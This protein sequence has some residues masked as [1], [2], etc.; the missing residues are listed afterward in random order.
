M[1]SSAVDVVKKTT[2]TGAALHRLS[3]GFGFSSMDPH[4]E[5]GISIV[6]FGEGAKYIAFCGRAHWVPGF[7]FDDLVDDANHNNTPYTIGGQYISGFEENEKVGEVPLQDQTYNVMTV[8]KEL[9]KSFSGNLVS[10]IAIVSASRFMASENFP[11]VS[12]IVAIKFVLPVDKGKNEHFG[13]F[14]TIS[15]F[16]DFCKGMSGLIVPIPTSNDKT[17]DPPIVSQLTVGSGGVAAGTLNGEDASYFA[18]ADAIDSTVHIFSYRSVV[19][20]DTQRSARENKKCER[21]HIFTIEVAPLVGKPENGTC[22]ISKNAASDDCALLVVCA[23]IYVNEVPIFSKVLTF[24]RKMIFVSD[25]RSDPSYT[26]VHSVITTNPSR[27][28]LQAGISRA[29]NVLGVVTVDKATLE[30]NCKLEIYIESITTPTTREWVKAQEVDIDNTLSRLVFR[31]MFSPSP[32]SDGTIVGDLIGMSAYTSVSFFGMSYSGKVLA[33]V[34]KVGTL[35]TLSPLSRTYGTVLIFQP[36]A[37]PIP[38][39][40]MNIGI[41][42]VERVIDKIDTK[43]GLTSDQS[44]YITKYAAY[45]K[46]ISRGGMQG[47]SWKATLPHTPPEPWALDKNS[48]F[49]SGVD[50][51]DDGS[52]VSLFYTATKNVD[53]V[54]D[55]NGALQTVSIPNIT[56]NYTFFDGEYTYTSIDQAGQRGPLPLIPDSAIDERL[57][58]P[59]TALLNEYG[60]S[61]PAGF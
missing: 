29:G 48:V 40:S 24:S 44:A 23:G 32:A 2:G 55:E 46:H 45:L 31:E 9:D 10:N 21:T 1:A 8:L 58:D 50:V 20:T 35:N 47:G 53:L 37:I 19:Y 49:I 22:M 52:F 60:L 16:E 17:P 25:K 39:K 5:D 18:A 34:Q 51:A 7:L 36:E 33:C 61:P 54:F 11:F 4:I 38:P 27:A 42:D 15:G 59:G 56:K 57:V 14:S 41:S 43:T 28:V 13:I 30:T 3:N 6:E 12:F 26:Q